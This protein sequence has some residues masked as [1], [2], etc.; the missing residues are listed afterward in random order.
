MWTGADPMLLRRS[1]ALR[2]FSST[3]KRPP[4]PDGTNAFE[5][6]FTGWSDWAQIWHGGRPSGSLQ[7]EQVVEVEVDRSGPDQDSWIISAGF[8]QNAPILLQLASDGAS[9]LGG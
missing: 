4:T 5:Y 2:K 8:D 7:G 3:R 6:L 1:R 9:D